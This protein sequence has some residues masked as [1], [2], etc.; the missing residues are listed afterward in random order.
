MG[1]VTETIMTMN[2]NAV[3]MLNEMQQT[4]R[5]SSISFKEAGMSGTSHEP[6]F[7]IV[8]TA[9][10]RGQTFMGEGKA[11]NKKAA[12]QLAAADV[13]QKLGYEVDVEDQ[14]STSVYTAEE[15][16][17]SYLNRYAQQN[18]CRM[19]VYT[20]G[21]RKGPDHCPTFVVNVTFRGK[22]AS[23]S[24]ASKKEAKEKAAKKLMGM[25]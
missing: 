7:T 13:L 2:Q 16:A 12:K 20:D 18:G 17:V 21:D 24:G 4:G 11:S 19:P 25:L 22:T 14:V 3:S 15:T 6:E 23:G 5:I 1:K 9:T 8:A 10:R